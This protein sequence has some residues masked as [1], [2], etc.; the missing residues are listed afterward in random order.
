MKPIN[1][2]ITPENTFIPRNKEIACSYSAFKSS[3]IAKKL[4]KILFG[5]DIHTDTNSSLNAKYTEYSQ[6]F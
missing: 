6:L 1:N 4:G 2:L 3:E 5:W